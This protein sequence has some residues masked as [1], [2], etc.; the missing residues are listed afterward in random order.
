MSGKL[1]M[2]SKKYC[3]GLEKR[4]KIEQQ[5]KKRGA[6]VTVNTISNSGHFVQEEQPLKVAEYLLQYWE[7]NR[8]NSD[9]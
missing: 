8:I 1:E 4:K 5:L 2:A 9:F 7:L 6:N 3:S